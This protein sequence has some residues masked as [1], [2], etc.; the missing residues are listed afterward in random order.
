MTE[1]VV[2]LFL[3]CVGLA[4]ASYLSRGLASSDAGDEPLA[5][6]SRLVRAVAE[7]F[8]RRQ[9]ATVAALAALFGGA[10]F[11]A[12]G[13]RAPTEGRVGDLEAAVWLV[14]AFALGVG[15]AIVQ[16]ELGTRI[17]LAGGR[18]TAAAARRNVDAALQASFR[19]GAA[20]GLLAS[21]LGVV[22]LG[23]L[24]LAIALHHGTVGDDVASAVVILPRVPYVVLGFALGASTAALFTQIAGGTFAK[25]ADLG[26]DLGAR[27]AGLEDDSREN[28]AAIANLAGDCANGASSTQVTAYSAAAVEDA[29]C[30]L[31][32]SAVYEGD[33]SLRSPLSL[34]LLPL[35]AR[36]FAILGTV[37]ATGV[38]RT[39]DRED[40]L[41]AIVRGVGVATLLHAVGVAGAVQWLLPERRWLVLAAF[42]VGVSCSIAIALWVHAS[43]SSR[44]RAV[45]DVADAARS[46]AT[47][48]VLAGLS[49]GVRTGLPVMA[50]LGAAI[51]GSVLLGSSTWGSVDGSDGATLALVAT[52]LGLLGT[53]TVLLALDGMATAVDAAFGFSTMA[54]DREHRDARGRLNVL[55]AAG[56]G[57]RASARV[58]TTA[59]TLVVVI[60]LHEVLPAAASQAGGA[61]PDRLRAGVWIGATLGVGLVG[62]LTG[63][64]V[65]GVLRCSRRIVEEVRRQ[66][67]DRS[68]STDGRSAEVDH[69]PCSE[70]AT[71][72]ALRHMVIA[73]AQ[74][75]VFAVAVIGG[76]HLLESEDMGRL[77]G[78]SVASL[79]VAATVAGVLGSLLSLGAEGAWG[80]AKKYIVTG[81]HGGRLHVDETGARAEN[82]TFVA[83]VVGD[84]VGDPLKDVAV[85]CVMIL[86]RMLPIVAL[87][88]SPLVH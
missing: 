2:V 75:L 59:A 36:A 79:I 47:L 85:P 35:L 6:T 73:G 12:Y 65:T 31:A 58:L 80:S 9:S 54:T 7:G 76:L 26:A 11:V 81:A 10:L 64:C 37:F 74:A 23:G 41:S 61:A 21:S 55:D 44:F 40:P 33:P 29:A 27:D 25:S 4:A 88:L 66:L 87:V 17:G 86:V 24:L 8:V 83:S 15:G 70:T 22:A 19:T 57:Q 28:P 52:L 42:L 43:T 71:R 49:S 62:W 51:A 78:G 46:G 16:S 3:S 38:V 56:A 50:L 67:R 48:N 14:L 60:L 82:P 77:S 84:T 72:F 18:R 1:L 63:R 68:P 69:T 13:V 53:S 20:L 30:L 5:A 34:L 39:D 45:R 32:V